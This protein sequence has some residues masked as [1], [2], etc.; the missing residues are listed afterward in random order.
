MPDIIS[1][2]KHR[3]GRILVAYNLFRNAEDTRIDKLNVHVISLQTLS[4]SVF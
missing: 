3:N 2:S 1:S 4:K